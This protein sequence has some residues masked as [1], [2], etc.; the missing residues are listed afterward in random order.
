MLREAGEVLRH[1]SVSIDP[2]MRLRDLALGMQPM[3]PIAR[4]VSL[5]ARV[6]LFDVPTSAL[7]GAEVETLFA[8]S[9]GCARRVSHCYSSVIACRRSTGCE[10]A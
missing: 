8:P 6:V 7:S 5:G 9:S 3:V 2:A 4:V 10:T 1:F